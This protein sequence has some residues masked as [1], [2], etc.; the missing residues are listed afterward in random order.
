[1]GKSKK[2][3]SRKTGPKCAICDKV[4]TA[5]KY[6]DQHLKASHPG[7]NN[8]KIIINNKNN[9]K[10]NKNKNLLKKFINFIIKI[11][12]LI[13]DN[14]E[15]KNYIG[16]DF[17]QRKA[18][19]NIINNIEV[20]IHNSDLRD[21][22][23]Q[24]L[25]EEDAY[26]RYERVMEGKQNEEK[27]KKNYEESLKKIEVYRKQIGDEE[28]DEEEELNNIRKFGEE[29]RETKKNHDDIKY[30]K[31]I[32][33]DNFKEA[34]KKREEFDEHMVNWDPYLEEV[35]EFFYTK[36]SV[37][38]LFKEVIPNK[39][40]IYTWV[41]NYITKKLHKMK[42]TDYP[43]DFSLAK[44]SPKTYDA[45]VL[46]RGKNPTYSDDFLHI[47]QI[48]INYFNTECG[49]YQCDDCH[50]FVINKKRHCMYCPEFRKKLEEEGEK[51]LK[52]YI[53]KNY[54]KIKF[55]EVDKILEELNGKNATYI[56]Q[57]LPRIIKY[58][59]KIQK[60]R[61]ERAR[62]NREFVRRPGKTL[63]DWKKLL[64]Q[65]KREATLAAKKVMKPSEK[66]K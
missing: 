66:L 34:M 50:K 6:L 17:Q 2:F 9:N 28:N 53:I 16:D 47:K 46:A 10:F 35:G 12:L 60:E 8:N 56:C 19:Y 26:D 52:L 25:K 11:V 65:L 62:A 57:N 44:W 33:K 55:T 51:K 40:A 22:A 41:K 13:N 18:Q 54:K 48:I 37:L 20:P 38:Q 61:R 42:K 24:T 23:N 14:I 45:I 7:A 63:K 15:I 58:W 5:Q 31:N 49:D 36:I 39:L 3:G 30:V 43:D 1:M 59:H 64:S 21:L 29:I 4:F 32:S 27:I